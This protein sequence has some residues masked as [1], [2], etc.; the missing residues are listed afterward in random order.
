MGVALVASAAKTLTHSTCKN[1]VT[2]TINA[3]AVAIVYYYSPT[4]I[5]PV[6]LIAGGLV[7]FLTGHR[8]STTS[9]AEDVVQSAG[10]GRWLGNVLILMWIALLAASTAVRQSTSYSSHKV[11]HWWET[12]YRI[13]SLIFGGGQVKLNCLILTMLQCCL[14]EEAVLQF[15]TV[16]NPSCCKAASASTLPLISNNFLPF[17]SFLPICY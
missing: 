3:A 17:R 4:W 12:F 15:A 13:G 9:A 14:V 16:I 2:L 1:K 6:L 8:N 5:F 11:F 7:T 10:V